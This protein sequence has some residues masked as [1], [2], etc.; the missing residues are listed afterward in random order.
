MIARD[1][2]I[3][4]PINLRY[5]E[6]ELSLENAFGAAVT[7]LVAEPRKESESAVILQPELGSVICIDT[8]VGESVGADAKSLTIRMLFRDETHT[9]TS[10]EAQQLM[11]YV[12]EQLRTEHGAV[13]R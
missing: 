9:L 12:V 10:G 5:A 11:D 7:N 2:S 13:Q 6:I 8:F 4:V 3:V 1:I